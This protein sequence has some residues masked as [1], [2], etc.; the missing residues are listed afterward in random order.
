MEIIFEPVTVSV[1]QA[2]ELLGLSRPVLYRLIHRK[3]FPSYK[4]GGRTLI[5]YDLLRAWSKAQARKEKE[6]DYYEDR[7][8]P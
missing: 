7:T 4:E 2:A 8:H 3:D 1:E 6:I 5:D